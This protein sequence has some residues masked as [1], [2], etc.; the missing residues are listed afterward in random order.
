MAF[1]V[2]ANETGRIPGQPDSSKTDSLV[3]FMQNFLE[4]ETTMLRDHY[5]RTPVKPTILQPTQRKPSSAPKPRK[6]WKEKP[7]MPAPSLPVVG[8]PDLPL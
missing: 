8:S 2:P 5:W 7:K 6:V 3:E 4:K 1:L